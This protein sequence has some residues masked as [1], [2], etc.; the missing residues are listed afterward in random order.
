[1]EA[2]IVVL[3]CGMYIISPLVLLTRRGGGGGGD[4]T[5]DYP[6]ASLIVVVWNVY[7][8][9]NPI[10]LIFP[11]IFGTARKRRRPGEAIQA[12]NK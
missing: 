10:Y 6:P 8:V 12:V 7:K 9:Y 5:D 2:I 3:S 11:G 1:M 4:S